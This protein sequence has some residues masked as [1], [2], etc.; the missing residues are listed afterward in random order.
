MAVAGEEDEDEDAG[1]PDIRLLPAAARF[2]PVAP[3]AVAGHEQES[4]W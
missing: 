4:M 1:R 3:T 2:L